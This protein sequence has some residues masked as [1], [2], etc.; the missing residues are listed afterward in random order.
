MIVMTKLTAQQMEQAR[1]RIRVQDYLRDIEQNDIKHGL[2]RVIR[3]ITTIDPRTQEETTRT[4][5][6]V[7]ELQRDQIPVD[8]DEV[9]KMISNE[10]KLPKKT[11]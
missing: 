9:R 8:L 3:R 4:F 7:V 1:A 2:T 6:D 5:L 10:D 11:T